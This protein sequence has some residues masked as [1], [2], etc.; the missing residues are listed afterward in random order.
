MIVFFC[1]CFQAQEIT[2]DVS[3]KPL[4]EVIDQ[5]SKDHNLKF[6]YDADRIKD[7]TVTISVVD[8]ELEDFLKQVLNKHG[9]QAKRSKGNFYYIKE[10]KATFKIRVV[11][12][13]LNE[14]VSYAT[15]KVKGSYRGGF[16]DDKGEANIPLD[17]LIDTVLEI[18]SVGYE[19]QEVS[20]KDSKGKRLE[21]KL[22]ASTVELYTFEVHEYINP[23]V[24]LFGDMSNLKLL[25]GQMDV[26][27]G[28]P[29]AD[30]LLSV[31]MLPGF[32]S[33]DESAGGLN[34]R[35]GTKDQTLVY[36]DRIPVYKTSHYFGSIT[37]FIPETVESIETYKNYIPT[38]YNG[39]TSGLLNISVHDSILNGFK[40]TSNTTFTHTDLTL[41][42]GAKDKIG[43]EIAG[44]SSYNQLM[45]TPAFSAIS[46]KLFDGTVQVNPLD[47]EEEEEEPEQAMVTSTEL[48]FWDING[49]LIFKPN[50]KNYFSFSVITNGDNLDF[51]G[52]EPEDSVQFDQQQSTYYRGINGLYKHKFNDKLSGGLSYSDSY[53]RLNSTF[54]EQWLED[55]D[56][57]YD[58][59]QIGNTMWNGEA[60]AW[61]DY[62][63]K[64]V[65]KIK[66]GYQFNYLYA[67]VDWAESNDFEPMINDSFVTYDMVNGVFIQPE[68]TIKK[69]WLIKP[70]LRVD[71]FQS[72]NNVFVNPVITT[73]YDLGKGFWL[74]GSYGH[75][76]QTLR[77]LDESS[78]NVSNASTGL[79]L[80]SDNNEVEVLE[81]KHGN[82]GF[83]FKKKGWLFDMDFYWKQVDGI[84]SLNQFGQ[85]GSVLELESGVATTK[86]FDIM[87]KKKFGRYSTWL[88]YTYSENKNLFVDIQSNPFPSTLDR[89]HQFRWT[90]TYEINQ[91]QVS[92]GW[93]YKSGNPYTRPTGV[94]YDWW[95]DYYQ[96]TFSTINDK[97]LPDYHRLDFSVWYKFPG[98]D[99]KFNGTVGLSLL[100]VYNRSNVWKRTYSLQ[101]TNGDDVPEIVENERYFLGFMPNITLKIQY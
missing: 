74:K 53:Y 31:Q 77:L 69:K 64:D 84:S 90:H 83:V 12:A 9:L 99:K 95:D 34:V 93:M 45:E 26:L 43:F 66:V 87:A 28:L 1:A 85:L 2:M 49:K 80:L 98:A 29:E 71:H 8:L 20:V 40:A 46:N 51:S 15:I 52:F 30:V 94:Y 81:C 62:D 58:S 18:S 92:L 47:G 19:T 33:N 44:R 91:F 11:D 14:G 13:E 55:D 35:G 21:V 67:V 57:S 89:P 16:A 36:W 97:R 60:R 24:Q 54:S 68:F 25:P 86:G 59:V 63:I 76:N 79:W 101:D 38:K 72:E 50:D 17:A 39:A 10:Q 42:G 6:S 65:G 41:R 100:N 23:A 75:Y 27:P 3:E 32:E 82:A 37:A 88:S 78:V 4:Q 5:I 22:K 56:S 61:L 48:T 96:M 73:Q 70:Q 7:L